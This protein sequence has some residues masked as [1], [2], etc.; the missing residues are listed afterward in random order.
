[1]KIVGELSVR[2]FNETTLLSSL[3]GYFRDLY[4]ASLCR[5]TDKEVALALGV[6]EYALKKRRE[7]ASKFTK[8]RLF[9]IYERV[10][11]A[12]SGIKNG[13]LVPATA[14]KRVTAELFFEKK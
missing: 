2:G 13:T 3:A 7:Q 14:L 10:Y 1:M 11:G 12:I 9:E 6:K 4:E 5:G 8:E